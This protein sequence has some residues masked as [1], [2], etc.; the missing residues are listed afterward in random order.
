MSQAEKVTLTGVSETALLTLNARAVEARRSDGILED[1]LAITLAD[2]IDYDFSKFGPTR[3]DIALRALAFDDQTRRFLRQHPT[4][5][6]V[7]LAEGLQTSYWRVSAGVPD[8]GFR[9]LTVDL[10]PIVE[11]RSRLLPAAP[12]I[13]VCAQSALDYSWMDRVD[14]DN[15]VFISAEGLLMY[16][17]PEQSLGLIQECARRFP[18]G[19][20][21]FDVPPPWMAAVIRRGVRTS[22]RYKAPPMPF[23]LSVSEAADL[24]NT[25]PGIRAVRDL[26][27]PA[28]RGLLFNTLLSA[29]YRLRFLDPLRP[30]LTLLEFG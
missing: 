18:G 6:V 23:N 19:R 13:S 17:Q 26:P 28:G 30:S 11:I 15:G 4:G 14:P 2:S 22:L 29:A 7:A 27:M 21:L 5:T 10:P 3:Q 24:V 20:M 12:K 9:W 8:T 25:M 16:L 1:P